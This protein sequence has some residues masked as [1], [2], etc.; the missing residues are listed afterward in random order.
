MS[1]P[2]NENDELIDYEEDYAPVTTA[3]AA[4]NGHGAAATTTSTT[5]ATAESDKEKK[6][7][8]GVH[9]TGFRSVSTLFSPSPRRR[10]TALTDS[11]LQ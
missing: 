1:A 6:G 5:T 3:P 11:S 2:E 7:Y 10:G 4:G 8:V 9:S